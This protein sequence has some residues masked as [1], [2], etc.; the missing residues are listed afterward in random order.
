MPGS[1]RL[2]NSARLVA[3]LTAAS[4]ILGLIRESVF[5]AFFSTSELLSAFR[6]AFMAPNL[7][8]RLFGEGA[9]SAAMIPVLTDTLRA[10][11]EES[12]RR[13]VGAVLTV[14][15]VV[16][17]A[18]LVLVETALLIAQSSS[19]SLALRL[20]IILMPYMVLIC[21][22]AVASGVLNVRQHFAVP[23]AAPTILNVAIIVAA[24]FGAYSA[25]LGGAELMTVVC[26]G[27]L[28]S[29][30]LQIV[31]TVVALHMVRFQPIY[32][33]SW[34][35]PRLA[36]VLR[37]MG[38][39]VLGLSAVQI[40]SLFD[41]LIAWF[42]IE[43]EGQRVGPA[44]LGFAQYLYQLP[45]GVFGISIATAVFPLLSRRA[46]EGDRRGMAE[47]VARGLR[48]GAFVSLPA[49]AGLIL[50]AHPLV[51]ALYERGEFGPA[52]SQRV[53]GTL[54]FYSLGLPAYFAQHVVVRAFYA[55]QDSGT[56]ARLAARMVL[57]NLAINLVLVFVLEERGLALSTAVCATVQVVWLSRRLRAHLPE[58]NWG[59]LARPVGKMVVAVAAMCGVILL[60]DR[61]DFVAA[62]LP[63]HVAVRL[64]LLVTSGMAT[65]ALA[66]A[67]LRIEELRSVLRGEQG[68]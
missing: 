6:I 38:P 2:V 26:I 56:P 9:L 67:L 24:L 51:A 57:F 48:L 45:L 50:V 32:G 37:L 5:A 46:A 1:G 49:T 8:R 30:V 7:A 27:I 55:L 22:V 60:L 18:L 17:I 13:F 34:R 65:Y 62:W 12:S 58:M 47:T 23:A 4:R 3:L 44:V 31:A 15:A 21:L 59:S 54:C 41:Y 25:G 42:F 29:G 19:D 52:Q 28:V 64:T 61:T 20:T 14:L 68:D 40:N 66:A 16:L 43:H 36:K 11:G 63:G 33:G 10:D 53:A 39:M 35:D